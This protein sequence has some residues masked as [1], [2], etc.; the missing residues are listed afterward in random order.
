MIKKS[1]MLSMVKQ[2]VPMLEM[3]GINLDTIL[4]SALSTLPE[5]FASKIKIYQDQHPELNVVIMITT[6]INEETKINE[7]WLVPVGVEGTEI[8]EQFTPINLTEI[9]SSFTLTEV[10]NNP[11]I[12]ENKL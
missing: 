3:A 2:A 12:L 6:R 7:F 4:Q 11:E 1:N 9:L 8:K 10:I 5:F